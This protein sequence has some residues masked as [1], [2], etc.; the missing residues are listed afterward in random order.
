M[1]E[2]AEYE[3]RRNRRRLMISVFYLGPWA[4]LSNFCMGLYPDDRD[5]LRWEIPMHPTGW[6]KLLGDIADWAERRDNLWV[7]RYAYKGKKPSARWR[8]V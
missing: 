1:T 8:R 3:T 5:G 7:E 6:R 4:R 2:T